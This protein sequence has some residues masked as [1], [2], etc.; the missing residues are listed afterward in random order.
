MTQHTNFKIGQKV[1]IKEGQY[2]TDLGEIIVIDMHITHVALNVN[3]P[4]ALVK[5]PSGN[6]CEPL[7]NLVPML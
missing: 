1:A 7:T 3:R 6:V 2:A 5:I 4:Q